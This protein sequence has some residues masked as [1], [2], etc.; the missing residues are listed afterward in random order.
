MRGNA[1]ELCF[2]QLACRELVRLNPSRQVRGTGK[3]GE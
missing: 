2:D 1:R 3:Q